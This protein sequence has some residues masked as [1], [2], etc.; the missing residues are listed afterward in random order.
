MNLRLS[1]ISYGGTGSLGNY[2][3]L[4]IH[5][6]YLFRRLRALLSLCAGARGHRTPG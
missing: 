3:G 5:V 4:E 6:A 2:R 1:N